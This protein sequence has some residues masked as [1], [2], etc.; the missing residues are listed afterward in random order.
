MMRP[1]TSIIQ[2]IGLSSMRLGS[3]Q[4]WSNW[5]IFSI[6]RIAFDFP[7]PVLSATPNALSMAVSF[8]CG[9]RLL[10]SR[11]L[12]QPIVRTIPQAQVSGLPLGNGDGRLR[13]S[14]PAS[15]RHNASYSS[16]RCS[17]QKASVSP[18]TAS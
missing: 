5:R 11:K 17:R 6:V 10:S 18:T 13:A 7:W 15:L 3:V 1:L 12:T 14:A 9:L 2:I 16:S 4:R 8:R